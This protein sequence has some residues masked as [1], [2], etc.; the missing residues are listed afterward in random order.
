M[1]SQWNPERSR[2]RDPNPNPQYRSGAA[3]VGT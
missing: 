3:L 1:E 2:A